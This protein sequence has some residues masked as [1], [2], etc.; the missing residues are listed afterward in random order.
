M[1]GLGNPCHVVHP[2][3]Q[4]EIR[5]SMDNLW[6]SKNMSVVKKV[7]VKHDKNLLKSY[8]IDLYTLFLISPIILF[9][10]KDKPIKTKRMKNSNKTNKKKTQL[11]ILFEIL[12][13]SLCTE[14]PLI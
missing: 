11:K 4:Q 13:H 1:L 6:R 14:P 12:V 2:T 3:D 8:S 7:L 9:K 5:F 10:N